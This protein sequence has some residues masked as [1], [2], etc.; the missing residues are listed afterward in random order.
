MRTWKTLFGL[1]AA[2]FTCAGCSSQPASTTSGE[3]D[4]TTKSAPTQAA[5]GAWQEV[6]PGGESICS[7]GSAYKFLTRQGDPSKLV[8]YL[9]GGGACWFRGNCDPAMK[10]TYNINLAQ[11]RGYQT[12]IFSGQ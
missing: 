1:A 8:V 12:G 5:A 4:A 9:Q 2:L 6:L 3:A 10:P 11:L 7:D